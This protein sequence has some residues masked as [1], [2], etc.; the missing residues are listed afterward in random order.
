M[1]RAPDVDYSA[2]SLRPGWDALPPALHQALAVALGTEIT[3][4]APPVGSGFTG[5][6]AA[7]A[8]L[9]DGR[10]VFVKAAPDTT[11]AHQAYQR[12][13]EVVPELPAAIHAPAVITTAQASDWFALVSEW[14]AGRMPGSPWTEDDFRLV[15]TTCERTAEVM[16]PSP[17]EGLSYF[18]DLVVDDVGVPAEILAGE[19]PLPTGL[20]PWVPDVL[21]QLAELVQQAPEAL[22]G[23]T[24]VHSDI[25]PD[26]LLIDAG[27]TCWTLDWNWLALGPAWIDWLGLLPIA[28][29]HGIDTFA[30]I[31]SSPLTAGVHE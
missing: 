19:R 20:Q 28:H 21:P 3:S 1:S 23:D 16:R 31:T 18:R 8:D 27:G 25:R 2:T 15:T 30:A 10:K 12:E 6:F 4:V 14:V 22:E 13:A 17:F 9:A 7:R 29:H 26:N 11:H 24:A 5:G